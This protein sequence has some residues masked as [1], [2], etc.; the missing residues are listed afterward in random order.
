MLLLLGLELHFLSPVVVSVELLHI[1]GIL[2]F[3]VL[4]VLLDSNL[5]LHGIGDGVVV[6]DGLVAESFGE[7]G[8]L[9]VVLIIER[10]SLSL[11]G[12]ETESGNSEN[13]L[14]FF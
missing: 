5:L 14:H 10:K 2:P 12:D 9:V 13:I 1:F 7:V 6:F 3:F 8:H 4:L 11:G